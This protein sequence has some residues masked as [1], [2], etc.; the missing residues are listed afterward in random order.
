MDFNRG[1]IKANS[2]TRDGFTLAI[3]SYKDDTFK[4]ITSNGN[5]LDVN[6]Y[7]FDKYTTIYSKPS[8][9]EYEHWSSKRCNVPDYNFNVAS[10]FWATFKN[11]MKVK[12]IIKDELF[13]VK[14]IL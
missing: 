1:V 11:R 4:A 8:N 10:L 2:K 13:I 14:K 7:E 3:I 6:A 5:K 12:G 9:S